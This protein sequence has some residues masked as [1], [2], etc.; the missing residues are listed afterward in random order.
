MP[1]YNAGLIGINNLS[2]ILTQRQQQA[3]QNWS[4][5]MNSL[6][7]LG[8]TG[9][10]AYDKY[11]MDQ[12]LAKNYD[13]ST[14]QLNQ[15]GVI[16]DL[17]QLNPTKAQAYAQKYQEQQLAQADKMA[18]IGQKTSTANK[19]NA[20]AGKAVADAGKTGYEAQGLKLK[21]NIDNL[22]QL[23][24]II[25]SVDP[26][27]PGSVDRAMGMAQ[28]MGYD[29]SVFNGIDKN[30]PQ[31]I[32]AHKTQATNYLITAK[33]QAQQDIEKF[34]AVN[35]RITANA[36]QQNANTT[37]SK[38]P[39]EINENISKA[40]LN[41]ANTGKAVAETQE[42]GQKMSGNAPL[43]PEMQIRLQELQ[44]KT[45]QEKVEKIGKIRGSNASNDIS[46]K[47]NN[48]VIAMA[49]Q[50]LADPMISGAVDE[51]GQ[52][53]RDSSGQIIPNSSNKT[54]GL[55][56]KI[57]NSVP[58][59]NDEKNLDAKLTT[60]GD[61]VKNKGIMMQKSLSSA[62]STGLGALSDK[63]G[64]MLGSASGYS[65][66]QW[67]KMSAQ[68]KVNALDKVI[69][70]A[71][72]QNN[73]LQSLNK[74]NEDAMGILSKQSVNAPT[75]MP[76]SNYSN[77]Q[78]G[79]PLPPMVITKATTDPT[80]GVTITPERAQQIQQWLRSQGR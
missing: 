72:N 13:Q 69:K 28:Q 58:F 14:G 54:S 31:S 38:A 63:E 52:F 40:G 70:D 20:D 18:D 7:S 67:L 32:I 36:T 33:D 4:Q 10:N 79:A 24:Q 17:Y 57:A 15:K 66:E 78:V 5:G 44:N 2:D 42:I 68:D 47:A 27:N 1:D 22:N 62:G 21:N 46:I 16:S 61:L 45:D 75:R 30:N 48:D 25:Q 39:S 80:T 51:K 12:I 19:N 3:D 74:K 8:Q 37:A 60:L 6:A 53:A 34:N 65:K 76:N 49:K 26:N 64:E 77:I 50:L 59:D 55:Y 9:I 11:N 41:N 29:T 73:I 23:Q 43:T 56:Y 71:E 35:G